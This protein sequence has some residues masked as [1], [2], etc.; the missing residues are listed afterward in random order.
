MAIDSAVKRRST[1]PFSLP[2]P[3]EE[4][5]E[6]KRLI[7]LYNYAGFD[8]VGLPPY[9]P[10]PMHGVGRATTLPEIDSVVDGK[11]RI[12]SQVRAMIRKY[13]HYLALRKTVPGAC[14]CV[15]EF[16][17]S[18]D[19]NCKLC[20]GIGKRFTDHISLGRIYTP[21]PEIGSEQRSPLGVTH[22][23]GPMVVTEPFLS[24]KGAPTTDDYIVELVLGPDRRTPRRPYRIRVVYK[25]THVDEMRDASGDV[26]FY[27]MSCEEKTWNSRQIRR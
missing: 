26:A 6:E 19:P 24:S 13:G 3:G 17:G 20:A 14:E 1:I 2:V 7:I 18:P 21:R 4:T 16:A 8:I 22:G 27:Q 9:D 5:E 11:M 10:P 15:K 12:D 23:H 25:I